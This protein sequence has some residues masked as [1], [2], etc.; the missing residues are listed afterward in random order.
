MS[1][2]LQIVLKVTSGP[3]EG[4]EFS[5]DGHDNFIV[6]RAKTAQFRLSMK[7]EYFSRNHFLV[8]VNPPLCRLLDL[9]STNGTFVNGKK[10]SSIELNDGDTIKAGDTTL[11]VSLVAAVA[12]VSK[13]VPVSAK[14]PAAPPGSAPQVVNDQTIVPR[15]WSRNAPDEVPGSLPVR[16]ADSD[17]AGHPKVDFRTLVPA[18]NPALRSKQ[19]SAAIVP[20]PQLSSEDRAKIAA[21]PQPFAGYEI[22]EELGRQLG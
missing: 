12:E 1:S 15:N 10:V 21:R 17:N 16:K 20:M 11:R 5:F 22:I 19:K 4:R 2:L 8:E 9:Q 6:G 7:D 18:V 13:P 14:A 3:H